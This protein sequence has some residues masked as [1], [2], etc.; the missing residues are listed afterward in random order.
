MSYQIASV[1][2]LLRNDIATQSLKGA[3]GDFSPALGG[4]GF[5]GDEP[6]MGNYVESFGENAVPSALRAKTSALVTFSIQRK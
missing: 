5:V 4:A 3:S 6:V 2:P 1:V